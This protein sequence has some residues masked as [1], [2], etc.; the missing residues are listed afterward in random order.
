[1]REIKYRMFSFPFVRL[2]IDITQAGVEAEGSL[3]LTIFASEHSCRDVDASPYCVSKGLTF[4]GAQ[5]N[6]DVQPGGKE[7]SVLEVFQFQTVEVS[8]L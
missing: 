8:V 2:I 7:R 1:M 4:R 5:P 6:T 3:K